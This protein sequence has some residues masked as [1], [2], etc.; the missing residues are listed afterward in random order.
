[1]HHNK[2]DLLLHPQRRRYLREPGARSD[3]EHPA[4]GPTGGY[5]TTAQLAKV[6]FLALLKGHPP[7][8]LAPGSPALTC[9]TQIK[10]AMCPKMCLGKKSP[11][12]AKPD[13]EKC[14]GSGSDSLGIKDLFPSLTSCVSLGKLPNLTE[15]PCLQKWNL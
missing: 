4:A 1:M 10:P 5:G 6:Y 13:S 8:P 2:S 3:W 14:R 9:W 7:Y 11:Q 12:A 15:L